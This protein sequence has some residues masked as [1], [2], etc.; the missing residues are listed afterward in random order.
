MDVLDI[1]E[2]DHDAIEALIEKL[3]TIAESSSDRDIARAAELS[4]QL[5]TEHALHVQSEEHV[6]YRA[7]QHLDP[8]LRELALAGGHHHHLVDTMLAEVRLLRPGTD[9]KLRAAI[10][11][12]HD[13]FRR[14]ARED[15]QRRIFPILRTAL[16]DDERTTLGKAMLAERERIRPQVEHDTERPR[17]RTHGHHGRGFR[18]HLHHH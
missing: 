15:E 10:G 5:A 9:G 3:E 14:H 13:L 1:I 17:H 18:P 6:V 4:Q 11:V 12:L 7:C 16:S 8:A 2:A